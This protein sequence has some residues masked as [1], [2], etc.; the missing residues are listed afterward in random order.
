[1]AAKCYT[2]SNRYRADRPIAALIARKPAFI[3]FQATGHL[4]MR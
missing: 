3:R 1:M 2:D 4:H